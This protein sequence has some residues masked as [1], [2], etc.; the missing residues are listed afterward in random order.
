MLAAGPDFQAGFRPRERCNGLLVQEAVQ[1][2]AHRGFGAA[3]FPAYEE[4]HVTIVR[5]V[6]DQ[7]G[8]AVPLQGYLCAETAF[9]GLLAA[10]QG[11][12]VPAAPVE[13]VP[14]ADKRQDP[15]LHKVVIGYGM[16]DVHPLRTDRR[17]VVVDVV[18]LRLLR[19]GRHP[20]GHPFGYGRSAVHHGPPILPRYGRQEGLAPQ[21]V[22]VSAIA[23]IGQEYNPPG[24]VCGLEQ[25]AVAGAL[26]VAVLRGQRAVGEDG[27][28]RIGLVGAV[29]VP[30]AGHGELMGQFGAAFRDQQVIPTVFPIDMRAFREPASSSSPERFSGAQG[31]TCHRVDL[32]QGDG[33]VGIRHHI[34]SPVFKIERRVDALLLQPYRF[35]PG[36]GRV[37]G[38]DHEVSAAAHVGGD[39]IERSVVVADGGGI[40][41]ER[42]GGVI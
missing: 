33:G 9:G 3:L 11:R 5:L 24:T 18:G 40:D 20:H 2:Y 41:A 4:L 30:A 21:V 8:L 13:T 36:A 35:A 7:A 22:E 23:A 10:Q 32:T 34:A 17:K 28:R 12:R 14:V 27:I 42:C 16:L 25:V 6:D 38:G 26:D 39:H 29:D 37:G 15:V 1:P 31:G 19:H